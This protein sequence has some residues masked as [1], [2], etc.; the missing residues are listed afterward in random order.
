[1]AME[2]ERRFL[3]SGDGWRQAPGRVLKQGF[4]A[5][6][7]ERVVRVRVDGEQ[8]WL[9]VKAMVTDASRL[10]FEYPIPLADAEQML[11]QVCPAAM[12]KSAVASPWARMSGKSMNFLATTPVW[13]WRKSN[14]RMKPNRSSGRP[15]WGRK[16]PPTAAT[17][18]PT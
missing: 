13:C 7:R 9:T 16:S 6:S 5:V 3:V 14:C 8:G 10:E 18:T 17:P 11:A 1:M 15:G 2:I 12:E 4:I